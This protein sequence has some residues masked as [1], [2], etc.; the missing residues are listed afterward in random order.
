MT[1]RAVGEQV[2][3]ARSR[4][5]RTRA[6]FAAATG[7][8]TRVLSDLETGRRQ[9]YAPRTLAAVEAALGWAPGTCERVA[10]GGRVR[11]E[12]DES[13]QRVLDAWPRLSPDA[14]VLVAEMVEKALR[15]RSRRG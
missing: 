4:R 11:M 12:M 13:L 7:L 15:T 3:R 9:R 2:T 10:Q 14:R 8:S 5:W 1:W 6:D